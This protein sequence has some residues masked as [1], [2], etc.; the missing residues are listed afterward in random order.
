MNI[1]SDLIV[2]TNYKCKFPVGGFLVCT[3]SSLRFFHSSSHSS[4]AFSSKSLMSIGSA[5]DMDNRCLTLNMCVKKYLSNLDG[6]GTKVDDDDDI[7][8]NIHEI[9]LAFVSEWSPS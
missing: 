1:F 3:Y 2:I 9:S 5:S 8:N 7:F 4:S 6:G